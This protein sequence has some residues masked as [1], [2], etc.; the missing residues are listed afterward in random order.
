MKSHN[1]QNPLIAYIAKG[2]ALCGQGKHEAAVN[3]F[4]KVLR[5]CDSNAKD[6]VERIKVSYA[7]WS[8][9]SIVERMHQ[10]HHLFRGRAS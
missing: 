4:N 1:G 5:D 9:A 10:V 7:G 6:F 8:V 2:T 3:V